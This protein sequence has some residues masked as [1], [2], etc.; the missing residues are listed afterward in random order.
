MRAWRAFLEAHSRLTTRLGDELEAETGLP[1]SWYDVLVHLAEA[2]GN[3]LRMTDLAGAV[4]LSKSGLT[5]LVDRLC[6]AGL[7][8][9]CP[10][11]DDR[12]GTFVELTEAGRNRLRAAS[13]V[14]L[15]GIEE[16]FGRHFT[17]P[18]ATAL[19]TLLGR[20]QR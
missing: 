17:G 18:E 3:R 8:A 12:R 19:A 4:L 13:P 11:P 14:H 1:L 7:V 10:D 2:T 9:R 5:R 15:R 16:H 6:A 20:I